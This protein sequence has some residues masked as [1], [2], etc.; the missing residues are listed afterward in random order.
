MS[1]AS[2]K[3]QTEKKLVSIGIAKDVLEA[4]MKKVGVTEE[5]SFEWAKVCMA[6]AL[7]TEKLRALTE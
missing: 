2:K 4:A 7:E 3:L 5:L 1:N 6:K